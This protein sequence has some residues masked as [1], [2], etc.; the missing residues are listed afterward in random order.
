[1][2]VVFLHTLAGITANLKGFH[3]PAARSSQLGVGGFSI[4]GAPAIGRAGR[5]Q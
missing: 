1:L 2:N 3:S 4:A 5:W